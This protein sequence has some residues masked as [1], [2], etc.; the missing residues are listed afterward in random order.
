MF[1]VCPKPK[2]NRVNTSVRG[3]YESV[4]ADQLD[5]RTCDD[6][7]TS[8]T[9]ADYVFFLQQQIIKCNRDVTIALLPTGSKA[10]A[11]AVHNLPQ[12]FLRVSFLADSSC[13]RL[14]QLLQTKSR[15][16]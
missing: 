10:A 3:A 13:R 6:G 11:P 14:S 8:R 16:W 1:H 15:T 5:V 12:T 4:N 2:N 9:A 7:V